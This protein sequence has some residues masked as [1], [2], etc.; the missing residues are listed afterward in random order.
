MNRP[1]PLN[2]SWN[3]PGQSMVQTGWE[4]KGIRSE[5]IRKKR[6]PWERLKAR[7]DSRQSRFSAIV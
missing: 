1:I 4:A 5:V 2:R 6:I 7:I 3:S